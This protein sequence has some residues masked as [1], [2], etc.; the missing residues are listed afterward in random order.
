MTKEETQF[1]TEEGRKWLQKQL[2]TGTV[3]VT[4]TK[5]DG[6]TRVMTAH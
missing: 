4:F 5:K 1:E 2:Q 3:T 6:E